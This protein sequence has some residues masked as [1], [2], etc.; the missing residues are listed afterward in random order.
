[1]DYSPELQALREN[2]PDALNWILLGI[3][4]FITVG[5]ILIAAYIYWCTSKRA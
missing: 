5:G 4:E 3:S 2:C 1:M